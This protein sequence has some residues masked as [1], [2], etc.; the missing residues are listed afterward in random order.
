M[1]TFV[2]WPRR[3]GKSWLLKQLRDSPDAILSDGTMLE[4]KL[5]RDELVE[6][7]GLT[8]IF[9]DLITAAP[10]PKQHRIQHG[11]VRKGRGG[12]PKRW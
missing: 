12:K 9:H 4:F 5:A 1:K 3:A 2:L 8:I 7:K 6:F 11:P 10:A